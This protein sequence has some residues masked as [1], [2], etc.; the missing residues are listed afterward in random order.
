[1]ADKQTVSLS[2]L[3]K[4][5]DERDELRAENTQL[6]L[7]LSR[8]DSDEMAGLRAEIERLRYERDIELNPRL[9]AYE[10]VVFENTRLREALRQELARAEICGE[11]IKAE[12]LRG[13]L[14]RDKNYSD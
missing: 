14:A 9:A 12:W 10:Q 4:A 1:M 7:T 11:Q 3:L 5:A 8:S 13:V 2:E 6:R